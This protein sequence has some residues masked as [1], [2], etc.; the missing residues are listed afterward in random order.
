MVMIVMHMLY[1]D[2][3]RYDGLESKRIKTILKLFFLLQI[4]KML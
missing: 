1:N 3:G 4:M 2:L